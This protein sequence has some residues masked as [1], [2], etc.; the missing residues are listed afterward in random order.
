MTLFSF[1]PIAL[2]ARGVISTG[3]L[4]FQYDPNTAKD[5]VEWYDNGEGDTGENV[6]KFFGITS[7]EFA[8]WN[9][10]LNL[11]CEPWHPSVSYCIV[12]ETKLN[13]TSPTTTYSTTIASSTTSTTTTASSPTV[14]TPLGCCV[15]DPDMPIL[16][17]NMSPDSD[18]SLTIPK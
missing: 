16:E 1:L 14:W 11:N 4:L 12:T 13:A 10:S 6:R 17:E 2:L 18:S 9:P 3:S 5:Y 7:E 15:E 8:A